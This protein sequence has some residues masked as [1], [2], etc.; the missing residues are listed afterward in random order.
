MVFQRLRGNRFSGNIPAPPA[1]SPPKELHAQASEENVIYAVFW[2]AGGII[3][4]YAVPKKQMRHGCPI[5]TSFATAFYIISSRPDG[6]RGFHP[7]PQQRLSTPRCPCGAVSAGE[8]NHTAETESFCARTESHSWNRHPTP[9]IWLPVTS[10]FSA[11]RV[12]LWVRCFLTRQ[13]LRS[14]IYQHG[15]HAA[16][17]SF[18]KEKLAD[19]NT[20]WK[21]REAMLNKEW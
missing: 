17:Q 21:N 6:G 10:V 15:R 9:Q 18:A 11:M 7:P 8:R 12:Y 19:G 5:W 16:E 3:L 1:L 4:A 13:T 14:S 20:V 2:D